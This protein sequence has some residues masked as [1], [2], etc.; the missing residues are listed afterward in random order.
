MNNYKQFRINIMV[1]K[2]NSYLNKADKFQIKS[3]ELLNQV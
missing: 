2:E 3:E 1:L